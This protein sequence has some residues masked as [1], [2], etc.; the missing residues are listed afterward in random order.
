MAVIILWFSARYMKER[1]PFKFLVCVSLASLIHN[2]A[3]IGFPL[4]PVYLFLKKKNA[5]VSKFLLIMV[6]SF[7]PI[8][9]GG[10]ISVL[11]SWSPVFAK[12]A[13][14]IN[15]EA[16]IAIETN[17]I[18]NWFYMICMLTVLVPFFSML[19]QWETGMAW[20]L[21]L[22][23]S[24][25]SSYLLSAYIAGGSR[26]AFFFE[27]GIMLGYAYILPGLKNRLN[28]VMMNSFVF[29]SSLFHF[30]YKFYICGKADIFPYQT[31][32]E[33]FNR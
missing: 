13:G 28:R 25:L 19:R 9:F 33:I 30:T 2:T 21:F 22:C 24:Q 29:G 31:V 20:Y 7:I 4:Y 23:L 15:Q 32:L 11:H 6:S 14:Y 16:E 18:L 1:K 5:R 8:I 27:I 17:W 3:V 10:C 26:M 12:Y